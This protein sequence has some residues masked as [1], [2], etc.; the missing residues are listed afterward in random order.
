MLSQPVAAALPPN[1]YPILFEPKDKDGK[2]TLAGTAKPQDTRGGRLGRILHRG[3][4]GSTGETPEGENADASES[5]VDSKA[6]AEKAAEAAEPTAASVNITVLIAMPS[7]KTVFPSKKRAPASRIPLRGVMQPQLDELDEETADGSMEK[8][9]MRRAPSL[10]S[11]RTAASAKS[12][13]EARREAYF[14]QDAAEAAQQAQEETGGLAATNDEDGEEEE[15]PELVFGTASVPILKRPATGAQVSFFNRQVELVHPTRGDLHDLIHS[16][17]TARER[18]AVADASRKAAEA[19]KGTGQESGSANAADIATGSNVDLEAQ[20]VERVS[21]S[22]SSPISGGD[23]VSRMINGGGDAQSARARTEDDEDD[24]LPR[25]PQQH[26]LDNSAAS[27]HPFDSA[28]RS[29]SSSENIATRREP[30]QQPQRRE[31]EHA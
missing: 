16:A 22:S 18:K 2:P 25:L 21:T 30:Q 8:G 6:A 15:L 14:G 13:A 27:W 11:I 28:L 9:K 4:A 24:E 10:R 12:L 17:K 31:A 3:R 19:R 26:P 29:S 5:P 20:R 23:V 7:A 1:L